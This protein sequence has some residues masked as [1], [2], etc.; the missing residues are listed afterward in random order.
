MTRYASARISTCRSS[1]PS[2]AISAHAVARLL[3]SALPRVEVLEFDT[4]GHMGPITDPEPVNE[5]IA[6]FLERV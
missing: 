3:T 4:L 5:A 2:F 6:R 1:G